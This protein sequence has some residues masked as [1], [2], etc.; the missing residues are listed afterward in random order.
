MQCRKKKGVSQKER[1]ISGAVRQSLDGAQFTLLRLQNSLGNHAVSHLLRAGAIQSK[2]RIS[3]PGDPYE[4]EADRV[5]DQ[6]M[7]MHEPIRPIQSS[8]SN[9]TAQRKC[10]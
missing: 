4:Q 3:N 6:V 8:S 2:L 10:A 7:R 1:G 9:P 5:A